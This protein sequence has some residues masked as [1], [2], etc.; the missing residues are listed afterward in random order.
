MQRRRGLAAARPAGDPRWG[1]LRGAQQLLVALAAPLEDRA[2]LDVRAVLL[3][4]GG[5]V[6]SYL[7][8]S[9]LLGIGGAA[10]A[11]ALR[12]VP[13]VLWVVRPGLVPKRA[14]DAGLSL[15]G[16]PTAPLERPTALVLGAFRWLEVV[17][18][19]R[20]ASRPQQRPSARRASGAACAAAGQ[21]RG[22]VQACTAVGPA[23]GGARGG[24]ARWETHGPGAPHRDRRYLPAHRQQH[25][26]AGGG[27]GHERG[28]ARQRQRRRRRRAG[29]APARSRGGGLGGR[30]RGALGRARGAAA[31][32]ARAA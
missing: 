1:P 21:L 13:G 26:G 25:G 5:W 8:D 23:A 2:V 28:G 17:H 30:G 10:A 9:A 29:R 31:A 32:R 12:R 14:A 4:H 16:C 19:T 22:G 15:C 11:R 27:R 7:P 6:S 24:C 20:H 3:A 18:H